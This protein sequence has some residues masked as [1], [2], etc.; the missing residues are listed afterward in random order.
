MDNNNT[1]SDDEKFEKDN[2]I[3]Y[4]NESDL[5]ELELKSFDIH[6]NIINVQKIIKIFKTCTIKN[7]IFQEKIKAD[8]GHKLQ[9][10][11]DAKT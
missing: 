7:G 2:N 8:L 5:I 10:T 1:D 6:E 3:I 4:S 9:L 11:L